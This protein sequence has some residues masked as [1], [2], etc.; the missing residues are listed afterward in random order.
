MHSRR[1]VNS[2]WSVTTFQIHPA[3]RIE[4]IFLISCVAACML[5]VI[6]RSGWAEKRIDSRSILLRNVYSSVDVNWRK[7]PLYHYISVPV[8]RDLSYH[9]FHW[10]RRRIGKKFVPSFF[11]RSN[12]IR[13]R[14]EYY[15]LISI[16]GLVTRYGSLLV[17][18]FQGINR[19]SHFSLNH[20]KWYNSDMI[21][22]L[23]LFSTPLSVNRCLFLISKNGNSKSS[24]NTNNESI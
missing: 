4:G 6:V 14:R 12:E 19:S 3:M 21:S 13:H 20:S 23:K 11:I 5:R 24:K 7:T 8:T 22:L 9:S 2:F 1:E 10:Y 15:S 16:N 18:C 17:A